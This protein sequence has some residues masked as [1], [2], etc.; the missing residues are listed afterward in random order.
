MKICIRNLHLSQ[1]CS[2]SVANGWGVCL[3]AGGP[4]AEALCYSALATPLLAAQGPVHLPQRLFT[5]G[6]TAKRGYV[7]VLVRGTPTNKLQRF[8]LRPPKEHKP[9]FE[10]IL[11]RLLF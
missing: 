1:S 7:H 10:R 11:F 5:T 9:C 2:S 6:L 8:P 4:S 3:C